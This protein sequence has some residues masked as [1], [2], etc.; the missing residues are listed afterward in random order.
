MGNKRIP[1][2]PGKVYHVY[3]HGNGDDN[4]FRQEK[5]YYRFLEKYNQ[6]LSVISHT[7]A[8]CL[9]PNHFHFLLMIKPESEIIEVFKT[10]YP[11]KSISE[12]KENLNY[13]NSNQFAIF[14]NSYSK[15]Y[16]IKYNRKGSLFLDNI[17]RKLIDNSG[18]FMKALNYIHF[19]PVM[20]GFVD[21]ISNYK[22][23][24]YY[25]YVMKKNKRI[26]RELAYKLFPKNAKID[27]K[28]KLNGIEK[29][30]LEMDMTF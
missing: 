22:F 17:E 16:N 8:Y 26:N 24:S 19:N 6:H 21:D 5:N 11:K 27:F 15:Y 23:T 18:Y 13:H 10:K 3:N 7:F 30:A 25:D 2:E 9:M 29:Y 14:L 4:I 20:H 28:P 12:L 1:F